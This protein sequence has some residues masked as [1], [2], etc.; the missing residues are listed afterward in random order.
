MECEKKANFLESVERPSRN[1]QDFQAHVS[2]VV[3]LYG[4]SGDG[5]TTALMSLLHDADVRNMFYDWSNYFVEID[6]IG[7]PKY[8]F[9]I[10]S[11]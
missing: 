5:K 9:S 6:S 10:T 2:A 7:C 1:V 8:A 4:I 11:A 3:G